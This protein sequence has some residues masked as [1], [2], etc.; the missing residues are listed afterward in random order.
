MGQF[1]LR[2]RGAGPV[3]QK[4]IDRI[5]ALPDAS[6][7]RTTDKMLLVEGHEGQLRDLTESTGDW[8]LAPVQSYELPEPPPFSVT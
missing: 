4:M 1:I 5:R 7:V 2:F 6:I 8:L 3:P